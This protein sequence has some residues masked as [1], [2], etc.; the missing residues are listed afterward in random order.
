MN[1]WKEL[2]ILKK[3]K[4]KYCDKDTGRDLGDPTDNICIPC[5]YKIQEEDS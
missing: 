2:I 4:C 3:M 5:V 1:K